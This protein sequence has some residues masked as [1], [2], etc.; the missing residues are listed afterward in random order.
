M[1][2]PLSSNMHHHRC[3]VMLVCVISVFGLNGV[4]ALKK[5]S[6]AW[7]PVSILTAL[8]VH[9]IQIF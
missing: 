6:W 3:R 8:P 4:V 7:T 1:F 2:M 5:E 9:S